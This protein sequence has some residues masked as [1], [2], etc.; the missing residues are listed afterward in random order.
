MIKEKII[1]KFKNKIIDIL[2][3][4]FSKLGL[5]ISRLSEVDLIDL[6]NKTI[7]PKAISYRTSNQNCL[8]HVEMDSGRGLPLF[9]FASGEQH[10][11]IV[12]IQKSELFSGKEKCIQIEKT[13][14]NYFDFFKP[15]NTIELFGLNVELNHTLRKIEP[16][17]TPM[18]WDIETVDE[19]KQ[20][21][22]RTFRR[23]NILSGIANDETDESWAW[24]GPCSII[25]AKIESKRLFDIYNS[26]KTNG[27]MRTSNRDGDILV[28]I[29]SSNNEDWC[30]QVQSGQHRAIALSALGYTNIPV[31]VVRV[32]HRSDVDFWPN[33]ERGLYSKEI[34]LQ[35][36][37]M[38]MN[39][40]SPDKLKTW[41]PT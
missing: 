6:R 41:I 14:R 40:K 16:R 35:I 10:P 5:K 3:L 19:W 8:I 38:I 30:W 4:M 23:E 39:N 27:Y 12:A 15:S 26:I 13:L 9:S 34:A 21:Q 28:S 17:Y 20:Q 11:Y 22:K 32:I 36:F 2:Q 31:R 25:K 33:V 7:H 24:T 37:D 18:P 29:L 1:Y